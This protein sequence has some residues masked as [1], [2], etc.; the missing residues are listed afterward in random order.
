MEFK[1]QSESL[2]EFLPHYKQALSEIAKGVDRDAKSNRGQYTTLDT[3]LAAVEPV[4][5]TNDLTISL[6]QFPY[7]GIMWLK[8]IVEHTASEQ[9]KAAYTIL[10]HI[11]DIDGINAANQQTIGAITTYQSRYLVRGLLGIPCLAEDCDDKKIDTQDGTKKEYPRKEG[12]ITKEQATELLV[13]AGNNIDR[14]KKVAQEFGVKVS[15]DIAAEDYDEA[16][17][18]AKLLVLKGQ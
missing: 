13:A 4:L 1:L 7:E 8:C 6:P 15:F 9:F 5:I 2:K 12:V 11:K 14:V 10:Y 16:L 17:K 3:M 18:Y